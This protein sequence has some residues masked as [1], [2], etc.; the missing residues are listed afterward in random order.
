M[1]F[2]EVLKIHE[3][4]NELFLIHQESLLRLDIESAAERLRIYERE[5]RAHMRVEEDQLMPVYERA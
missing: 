1:S 5:L 4:L 2:A 3:R